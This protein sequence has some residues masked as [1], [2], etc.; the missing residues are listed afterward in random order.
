M[1]ERLPQGLQK[2]RPEGPLVPRPTQELRHELPQAGV[3]ESVVM[4]MSGH[5]TRAVFDRY[6][7]VEE[8]DLRAA[9]KTIEAGIALDLGHVL[10]TAGKTGTQK[11]EDPTS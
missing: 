2:G 6:N 5:K 3:P 7:I 10:D 11:V 1:P 4:K 8:E 9:V